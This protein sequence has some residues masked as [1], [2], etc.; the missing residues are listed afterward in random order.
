MLPLDASGVALV[1][2]TARRH[3]DAA[4]PG[5]AELAESL[6]GRRLPI[7]KPAARWLQAS[8]S[9]WDLAQFDLASTGRARASKKAAAVWR[10]LWHAPEWRAARWG[11]LMLVWHSSSASTPGP[12][13]SAM[14][15]TP[16]AR[17]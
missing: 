8:R 17:P 10:A 1:G 11:A 15:S 6:L 16:S 7:V 13:R 9:P 3:G 4:E 12:G 5:V 14:R 2:D